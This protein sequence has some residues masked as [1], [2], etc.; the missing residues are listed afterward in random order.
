MPTHIN[1]R[2]IFLNDVTGNETVLE[3]DLGAQEVSVLKYEGV[4]QEY[5][6]VAALKPEHNTVMLM[7]VLDLFTQGCGITRI[8]YITIPGA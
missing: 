7:A 6:Y 8:E 3:L 2:Y 4:E 1:K 5:P